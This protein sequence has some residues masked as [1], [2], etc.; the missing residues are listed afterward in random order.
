MSTS[1]WLEPQMPI[2]AGETDTATSPVGEAPPGPL[3]LSARVGCGG[4]REARALCLLGL[5]T[6]SS[7]RGSGVRVC[8][9]S[10][11]RE[12]VGSL[13]KAPQDKAAENNGEGCA[14]DVA[15][16]NAKN[17]IRRLKSAVLLRRP[18][19]RGCARFSFQGPEEPWSSRGPG[20]FKHER[21]KNS[22]RAAHR[23]EVIHQ[24]LC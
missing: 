14:G 7:W 19:G 10:A 8:S 13:L 22:Q 6:G 9:E 15:C 3:G 18:P 5:G 17:N 24:P 12:R 16:K 21:Q 4:E 20:S 1:S 2:P 11:R 23:A